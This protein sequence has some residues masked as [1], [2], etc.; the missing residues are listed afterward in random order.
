M[1]LES[2]QLTLRTDQYRVVCKNILQVNCNW[3]IGNFTKFIYPVKRPVQ[4]YYGYGYLDRFRLTICDDNVAWG[5]HTG[6]GC[7]FLVTK[8]MEVTEIPLNHSYRI[9][10]R[11]LVRMGCTDTVGTVYIWNPKFNWTINEEEDGFIVSQISCGSGLIVCYYTF[12][13]REERIEVW[14][15]GNPPTLLRTLTCEVRNLRILKVDKRFIVA[16]FADQSKLLCFISTETLEVFTS[17]MNYQRNLYERSPE[18]AAV[19][20]V[21]SMKF[22]CMYNQGL[23]LSAIPWQRS[24]SNFGCRLWNICQ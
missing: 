4:Y 22:R 15:M 10:N 13:N 16:R 3:R 9:V 5:P 1:K 23:V 19:S 11:M 20:V 17:E 14:K 21:R 2:N 24:G 7:G 12:R 18:I 6:G 8:A